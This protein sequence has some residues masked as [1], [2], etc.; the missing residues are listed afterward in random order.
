MLRVLG[1]TITLGGL[2]SDL[3]EIADISGDIVGKYGRDAMK[4]SIE[5]ATKLAAALNVSLDHLVG[6]VELQ[7]F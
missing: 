5:T 6:N 2:R 1:T 4:P 3:D 7:V